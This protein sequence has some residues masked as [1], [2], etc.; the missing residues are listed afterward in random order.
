MLRIEPPSDLRDLVWTPASILWANGGEA[1]ALVPTRYPGSEKS[2]DPAVRLAR[3]TE[4]TDLADG[5]CLG[6]GQ[7][8]LVT[9]AGETALLEVREMSFAPLAGESPVAA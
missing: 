6:L 2:A 3:R 8:T 9:D 1:V 7:R 4:W 5:T